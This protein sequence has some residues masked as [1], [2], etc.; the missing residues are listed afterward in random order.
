MGKDTQAVGSAHTRN[1]QNKTQKGK[2]VNMCMSCGC[3]QPN[4]DHGD[5]RNITLDKL[6]QAG[7]AADIKDTGAVIRNMESSWRGMESKGQASTGRS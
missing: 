3:D 2:G 4:Q 1:G 5:Q 6:R 7:E